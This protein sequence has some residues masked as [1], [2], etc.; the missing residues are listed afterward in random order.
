MA[1][2]HGWEDF[3]VGDD[4]DFLDFSEEDEMPPSPDGNAEA[5]ESELFCPSTIL[6]QLTNN[7][8]V[9]AMPFCHWLA[10]SRIMFLSQN[11]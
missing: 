8:Y 2:K 6:V 4:V 9:R 1:S 7:Q 10:S 3:Y 11:L 5:G